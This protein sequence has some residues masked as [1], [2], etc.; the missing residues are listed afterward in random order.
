[1]ICTMTRHPKIQMKSSASSIHGRSLYR[2]PLLYTIASYVLCILLIIGYKYYIWLIVVGHNVDLFFHN[3][4]LFAPN[5]VFL[6]SFSLSFSALGVGLSFVYGF[7]SF[8]IASTHITPNVNLIWCLYSVL[9][10]FL[11]FKNILM[12]AIDKYTL[13]LFSFRLV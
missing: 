12:V 6:K 5:F 1:M 2:V 3:V 4:D 9:L 13:Y 7:V 10:S 11:H 8:Y